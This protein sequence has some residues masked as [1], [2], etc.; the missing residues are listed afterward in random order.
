MIN[1]GG[2]RVKDKRL[3]HLGWSMAKCTCQLAEMGGGSLW[4]HNVNRW[5]SW[6]VAPLNATPVR[7]TLARDHSI[8]LRAGLRRSEAKVGSGVLGSKR[9]LRGKIIRHFFLL[10]SALRQS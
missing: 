9:E 6:N 8:C 4:M 3:V 10:D 7:E 1:G 5:D 2:Q